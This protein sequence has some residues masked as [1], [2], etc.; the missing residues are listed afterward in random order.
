[1]S[2][3]QPAKSPAAAAASKELE[4]LR[5]EVAALRHVVTRDL[6]GD[7]TVDV[8]GKGKEKAKERDDDT[9]YFDSYAENGEGLR[10]PTGAEPS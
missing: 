9:H 10:M 1:M 3:A 6:E 2:I 8:K 5:A 4:A 7:E